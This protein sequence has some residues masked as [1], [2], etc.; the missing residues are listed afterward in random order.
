V[1]GGDDRALVRELWDLAALGARY[2]A[3]VRRY[4]P[5]ARSTAQGWSRTPADA[6]AVRFAYMFDIFRITWDDPSLPAEFLPEGWLGGE[7]RAIAQTLGDRLREAA[8]A[9][10]ESV[11]PPLA[12]ARARTRMRQPSQTAD[13][14]HR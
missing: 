4:A 14:R 12:T 13:D 3:F 1:G 11:S 5:L 9:F 6:F 2:R 7:A 10:A 8:L